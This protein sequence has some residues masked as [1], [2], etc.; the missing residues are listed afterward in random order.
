M[1]S[2]SILQS[3]MD[4]HG[5]YRAKN[6]KAGLEGLLKEASQD[7]YGP[8]YEVAII[9]LALIYINGLYDNQ[10]LL[11]KK[12]GVAKLLLAHAANTGI[13]ITK[14]PVAILYC[15]VLHKL[16][17][18]IIPTEEDFTATLKIL[19]V[20]SVV[21][22][23]KAHHILKLPNDPLQDEHENAY[24]L[25]SKDAK[26]GKPFNLF[27][28]ALAYEYGIGTDIDKRKAC[29][30]YLKARDA[31]HELGQQYAKKL[32]EEHRRTTPSQKKFTV[33]QQEEG[34]NFSVSS[35]KWLCP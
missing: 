19:N 12:L 21:F 30:L 23:E 2:P 15:G 5:E 4:L 17:S 8:L 6:V 7:V 9:T 27:N 18:K 32:L 22:F 29:G 13:S 25:L 34:E 11:E 16:N 28:L 3:L 1:L 10:L 35:S 24:R 33:L 31:G 20:R 14:N 26:A